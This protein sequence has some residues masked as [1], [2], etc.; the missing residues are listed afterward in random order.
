MDIPDY[1]ADRVRAPYPNVSAVLRGSTPVVSFGN[2][3]SARVATL[4]INPSDREFLKKGEWLPE[5]ER[6]LETLQSLGLQSL[7]DASSEQVAQIVHGCRN[8][9]LSGNAYWGWFR[10][11]D[12]LLSQG[13]DVSYEDGSAVHLDLI[14][15]ATSPTWGKI[16]T[17]EERESLIYADREFLRRQLSQ[18]NINLVVMNGRAVLKQ[19]EKMGMRWSLRAP[20]IAG[21]KKD[22]IVFGSMNGTCFFGWN[23]HIQQRQFT[24]EQKAQ[25]LNLLKH[26]RDL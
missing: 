7:E 8:Y 16:P 1:V 19:V 22:E 18:E 2:I 5:G 23:Y 11:L 21:G 13:L 26:W 24:A 3:T 9:F 15:W 14:Q 17:V 10:P 4:A 20:L 12:R 6:R 25:V